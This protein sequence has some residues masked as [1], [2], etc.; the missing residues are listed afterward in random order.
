MEV[1]NI[2][3]YEE[4]DSRLARNT[5]AELHQE[6]DRL[7]SIIKEVR[8]YIEGNTRTGGINKDK[9]YFKLPI[10]AMNILEILDKENE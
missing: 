5:I 7:E 9:K 10:Q 6:I 3:E 4:K 1:K 8:E 2:A